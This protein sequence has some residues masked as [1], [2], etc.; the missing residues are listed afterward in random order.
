[1][2]EAG[3]IEKEPSI[4]AS[5]AEEENQDGAE[6][7]EEEN[8]ILKEKLDKERR[9]AKLAAPPG[10]IICATYEAFHDI[11]GDDQAARMKRKVDYI[12]R[13]PLE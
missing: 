1:M 4:H 10:R 7:E 11:L 12:Q 3:Q 5:S 9:M 2:A 6:E 13:K 8:D